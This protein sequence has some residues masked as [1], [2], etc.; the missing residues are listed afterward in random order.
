MGSEMCIRDRA[1]NDLITGRNEL[2]IFSA[3]GD[4]LH[5][6]FSGSTGDQ[7]SVSVGL[8]SDVVLDGA[9]SGLSSQVM[10]GGQIDVTLSEGIELTPALS[11]SMLF[12]AAIAQSTYLGIQAAI[13]GTPQAGDE[14]RLDFNFD[15]AR[16]NRNA[17]SMVDFC[18][19]YTSPSPRDLSTSR[20]P[21]SA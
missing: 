8:N 3:E 19:L 21:S 1:S 18:L 7:I 16:D 5:I 13:T 11:D 15:A 14:F 6:A 2:Q 10:V 9:G 4:N 17:L 20:M 12:G